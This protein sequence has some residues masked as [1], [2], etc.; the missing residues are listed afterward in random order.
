MILTASIRTMATCCGVK[1]Y[2]SFE[3]WNNFT[4][5]Y[6]EE[7]LERSIKREK[8]PFQIAAFINTEECKAAY[9]VMCNNLKLLYQT[10]TKTNPCTG[11]SLFLCVFTRE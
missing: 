6:E 9:E 7:T 10:E 11:N 8:L 1:E 2:G 5:G 3:L 4:V